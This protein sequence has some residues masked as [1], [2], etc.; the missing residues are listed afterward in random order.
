MRA[1]PHARCCP[2]R[3]VWETAHTRADGDGRASVSRETAYRRIV[4]DPPTQHSTTCAPQPPAVE[5]AARRDPPSPC[6]RVDVER[7]ASRCEQ[8]CHDSSSPWTATAVLAGRRA[9]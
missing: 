9:G 4:Q 2:A 5:A 8:P 1:P 3:G 6:A 7:L